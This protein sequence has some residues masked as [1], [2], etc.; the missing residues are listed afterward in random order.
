[1]NGWR[2]NKYGRLHD[3]FN[4]IRAR[5]DEVLTPKKPTTDDRLVIPLDA[6]DRHMADAVGNKMANLGA[7]AKN[8]DVTTPAGF[9]ITAH[10]WQRF[11]EHND[12]QAEIE[13]RI[14]SVHLDDMETLYNL[15]S[16]IQQL[17]IRAPVP[18]DVAARDRKC[19]ESTRK[20][21][22]QTHYGGPAQQRRGR[23]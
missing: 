19:L 9:A 2:P 18:K 17:I 12:L 4:A 14:Q 6:V 22:R 13:R 20:L 5:I 23:R 1:M 7:I 3:R 10:A 11:L 15:S 16:A 21:R 8:L